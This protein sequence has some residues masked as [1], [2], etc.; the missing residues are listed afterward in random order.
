MISLYYMYKESTIEPK[1]VRTANMPYCAT[2]AQ[3]RAGQIG[4][5]VVIVVSYIGP[6]YANNN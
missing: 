1:T 4:I 2:D 3:R 6:K 5:L